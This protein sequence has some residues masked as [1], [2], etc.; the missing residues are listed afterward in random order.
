M[1]SQTRPFEQVLPFPA[2]SRRPA[3]AVKMAAAAAA[4]A[5]AVAVAVAVTVV[6]APP[7]VALTCQAGLVELGWSSGVEPADQNKIHLACIQ[8]E[9][10][11]IQARIQHQ[12]LVCIL[13]RYRQ[14]TG[15]YKLI[16]VPVFRRNIQ[17]CMLYVCGA[18]IQAYNTHIVT[19][20]DTVQS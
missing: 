3:A 17:T 7:S 6:A 13:V 11:S 14:Y 12:Y 1:T 4:A 20:P 10:Q 9:I 15:T 5:V 19:I 8:S 16:Y 18:C 2:G